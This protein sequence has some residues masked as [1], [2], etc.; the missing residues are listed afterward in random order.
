MSDNKRLCAMK[1]HL[2]LKKVSVG[3]EPW[4]ARSVDHCLTHEA[5]R[6]LYPPRKHKS[7][8]QQ[9]EQM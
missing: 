2:Y 4:I 7:S 3:A 6:F 1:F 5:T 8:K 9:T